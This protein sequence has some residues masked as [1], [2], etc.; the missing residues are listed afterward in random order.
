M[1]APFSALLANAMLFCM[2][3]VIFGITVQ[4]LVVSCPLLYC[5]LS[6]YLLVP[7]AWL[8]YRTNLCLA[9]YGFQTVLSYPLVY[10]FFLSLDS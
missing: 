1:L 10:V 2:V 7:Y 9:A 5:A 6:F 4:S 8:Q 3:S